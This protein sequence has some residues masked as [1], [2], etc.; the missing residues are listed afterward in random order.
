MPYKV[1]EYTTECWRTSRKPTPSDARN[2]QRE[3]VT[4]RI[5]QIFQ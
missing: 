1:L 3:T 2:G 4:H 5:R